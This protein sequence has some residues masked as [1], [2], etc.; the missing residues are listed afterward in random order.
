MTNAEK[1][2]RLITELDI[3]YGDDDAWYGF[4]KLERPIA[5]ADDGKK[6]LS[7]WLTIRRG[8]KREP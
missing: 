7:V 5:P 3:L 8:V 4:E 6:L 2:T 1:Q